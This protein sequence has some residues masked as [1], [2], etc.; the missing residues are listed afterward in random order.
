VTKDGS[1]YCIAHVRTEIIVPC[2]LPEEISI[3]IEKLTL[4][5]SEAIEAL[6]ANWKGLVGAQNK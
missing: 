6:T 4:W 2:R 1:L 3:N 5:L